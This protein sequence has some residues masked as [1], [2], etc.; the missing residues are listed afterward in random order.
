MFITER[1]NKSEIISAAVELADS[2]QSRIQQL[3]ERQLILAGIIF[4]LSLITI[5]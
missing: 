2:Q 4:I 3:E 1:S 5:L